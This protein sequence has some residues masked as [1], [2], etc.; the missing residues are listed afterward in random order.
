VGTFTGHQRDINLAIDMLS[1]SPAGHHCDDA[2]LL[3]GELVGNAMLHAGTSIELSVFLRGSGVRI[4]V[5]DGSPHHPQELTGA[6]E[7][8]AGR[9]LHIVDALA[10]DWGVEAR[11][12]GGKTVWCELRST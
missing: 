8:M 2:A 9:G 10:H 11:P 7:T 4:E 6:S 1:G 5:A 3:V 12:A